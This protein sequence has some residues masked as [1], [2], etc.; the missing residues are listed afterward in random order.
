[1]DIEPNRYF[2]MRPYV[3]VNYRVGG[4][5]SLLLIGESHYLPQKSTQHL[6]AEGWYAGDQTT[7]DA[8]EVEWISTSEIIQGSRAEGFKNK[9]HSIYRKA[10]W[11]INLHG[12]KYMDYRAVADDVV[13]YN[14]FHRPAIEG[15][16]LDPC[17]QDIDRANTFFCQ[18]ISRYRPALV[19]FLSRLARRHCTA[20][21]CNDVRVVDTPHP[22]C[23]HWNR[24]A[25]KYGNKRG[26]EILS[27]AIKK[28]WS[29]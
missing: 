25:K 28:L 11:E 1:M 7:L 4:E 20:A 13:F 6:T 14:Y 18:M 23:R 5:K 22:G 29:S 21:N 8:Q 24:V 16:S 27:E 9:A 2:M 15:M 12:P 3:G 17:P 10:F 26:R 19:V